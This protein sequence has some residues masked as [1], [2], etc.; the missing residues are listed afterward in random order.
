VTLLEKAAGQGHTYA[1]HTLGCFH[2]KRVEY[3]HTAAWYTKGAEAGLPR[4]TF[5]LGCCLDAGSAWRRQTNRRRRTGTRARQTPVT[6]LRRSTS[7]P[8]TLQGLPDSAWNIILH[9]SDP[10]FLR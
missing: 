1:V 7:A 5:S 8:C 6:R 3:E 9:I 4:V 2:D 10:R